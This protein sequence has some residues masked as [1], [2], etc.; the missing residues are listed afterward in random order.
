MIGI[1]DSGIGGLTVV[2]ALK[3][4]IPGYDIIFF[5][6]TAR[7]PYGDKSS[8][9]I[10]RYTIESIGFLSEKG[11]KLI[12]IACDAASGFVNKN[13]LE[14]FDIPIFEMITPAIVS[15]IQTSEKLRI[16]VIGTRAAVSSNIYE[17]KIKAIQPDAKVY[18]V[19]C[20]LLTPLLEA[21]WVKKPETNM[22]IKKYLH[23]L[24][25]RQIDT[26]ILGC[27]HYPVLKQII[28][29]KIGKRVHITDSSL[30]IA[31]HVKIFLDENPDIEHQMSKEGKSRFFVSDIT[32]HLQK[33]AK[34]IIRENVLLEY[35]G[36]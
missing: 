13:I 22:I 16:G 27:S 17:E 5:G 30:T 24:K 15:S 33:T 4:Q 21:D 28:Q 14:K 10:I 29:R 25:V 32:D 23:P 31:R 6:D 18:T 26:L 35:A 20:P 19:A 12:V 7:A 2:K 9:N 1:F 36:I 11:A 8:E 3:E 34:T